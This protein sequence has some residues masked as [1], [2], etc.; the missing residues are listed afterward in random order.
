MGGLVQSTQKGK[1]MCGAK[2]PAKWSRVNLR[3]LGGGTKHP[4][5]LGRGVVKH[6]AKWSEVNQISE[7]RLGQYLLKSLIS[8]VH[9]Q[10]WG[11]LGAKHPKV[12][13]GAK[14]RAKWSRV[15]S[16]GEGRGEVQGIQ[17]STDPIRVMTVAVIKRE[18]GNWWNT[19]LYGGVESAWNYVGILDFGLFQALEQRA[20]CHCCHWEER[21]HH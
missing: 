9:W 6:R 13:R 21:H 15:N 5:V 7:P 3:H 8:S 19:R 4:E 2:H 10:N 12:Q 17:K 11:G 14:H 1:G 18:E 16:R 20:H